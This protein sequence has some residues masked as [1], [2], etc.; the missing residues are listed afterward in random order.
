MA[1]KLI[2][3]ILMLFEEGKRGVSKKNCMGRKE[4]V[5]RGLRTYS[6]YYKWLLA[7]VCSVWV[8]DNAFCGV[9]TLIILH[10]YDVSPLLVVSVIVWVLCAVVELA[11]TIILSTRW[12]SCYFSD[13]K[14]YYVAFKRI[15]RHV[16][17]QILFYA[18]LYSIGFWKVTSIEDATSVVISVMATG[19]IPIG[20]VLIRFAYAKTECIFSYYIYDKHVDIFVESDDYVPA[21]GGVRVIL[22]SGRKVKLNLLKDNLYFLDDRILVVDSHK[23]KTPQILLPKD[24]KE[25]QVKLR[26]G[27]II[28]YIYSEVDKK[29]IELRT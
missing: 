5:R 27:R 6:W 22:S 8:V 20:I 19:A 12:G 26:S 11:A 25:I 21:Q 10:I 1:D 2:G 16:N 23:C 13:V 9:I 17:I 4:I 24:Y 3:L 7:A 29:W 18:I 14:E 15:I 28:Q